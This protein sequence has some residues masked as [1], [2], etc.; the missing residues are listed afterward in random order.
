VEFKGY[1]VGQVYAIVKELYEN[2]NYG[3]HNNQIEYRPEESYE[4]V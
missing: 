3:W 4:T 2:D 1:T